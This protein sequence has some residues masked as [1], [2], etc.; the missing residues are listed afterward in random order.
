[1]SIIRHSTSCS[2]VLGTSTPS[3]SSKPYTGRWRQPCLPQR[4][5]HTANGWQRQSP[6][7]PSTTPRAWQGRGSF[8]C[9]SPQPSPTSSCTMSLLTVEQHST[10]SASRLSRSCISQCQN[11][12]HRAHS[13]EW[14]WCRSYR[15]VVSSSRSH[16]GCLGTS[17]Q[18]AFYLTSRKSASP[19]MPFSVGQPCTS[20]WQSPIMGT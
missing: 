19:S 5:H 14:A 2:G 16:S 7:T 13:L 4:W 6:L 20:L 15:V 9:S 3:A 10:S 1:M 12:S 11:S 18:R 8:N 17:A